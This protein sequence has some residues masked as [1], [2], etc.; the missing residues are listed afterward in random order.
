MTDIR[1]KVARAICE[2]D[3]LGLK[4]DAPQVYRDPV[5]GE[6]GLRPAWMEHIAQADAALLACGYAEMR[7]ALEK[8]EQSLLLA[9]ELLERGGHMNA[10]RDCSEDA[11]A[12]R[13]ILAR[14]G[15]K[16]NA[17]LTSD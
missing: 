14:T 7:K 13:S 8:A 12:A 6:P 4:P 9:K 16:Q 3:A 10:A 17:L 2:L 15:E 5:T 1:E 11:S